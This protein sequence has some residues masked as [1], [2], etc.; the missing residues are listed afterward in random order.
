MKHIFSDLGEIKI[1][2]NLIRQIVEIS[3]LAVEGVASL[4]FTH[5]KWLAKLLSYL[6]IRGIKVDLSKDLKLEVPIIVKYGY[7]IPEVAI[8]VQE[9]ILKSLSKTLNIDTAYI[10]VKVKGLEK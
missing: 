9:E 8:H 4:A 7:N 6:K 2:R 10:I 3:T 1:H 5:Q